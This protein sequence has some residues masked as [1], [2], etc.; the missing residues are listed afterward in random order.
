MI[1]AVPMIRHG[2][3]AV[4]LTALLQLPGAPVQAC[5]S[6]A[7]AV[8]MRY[9]DGRPRGGQW[10]LDLSIRHIDQSRRFYTNQAVDT[11]FRPRIDL[12]GRGYDSFAHQE[13]SAAMSFVQ[14]EVSRGITPSL[15]ASATLP[16][17]RHTVIDSLHFM[18]FTAEPQALPDHEHP[19]GTSTS[20][21]IPATNA[22]SGIGDLQIGLQNVFWSEGTRDLI[23]GVVVKV[24]TGAS[25]RAGGDGVIDPMLQPGT[26]AVD[27]V[28]SLQYVQ[29]L[30]PT[31]LSATASFQKAT[32]NSA[33]YRYGDDAVAAISAARPLSPRV[34]GQLQMKAQRSGRH[35]FEGSAVPS[36]GLFLVQVAPGVRVRVSPSLSAYATLQMPAYVHVNE[37]QLAPRATMTAGF[38]KTF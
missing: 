35:R 28:G 7:C 26:G 38:A 22:A 1:L 15:T 33:R 10:R 23:G 36:T 2:I 12:S 14:V 34:T 4:V 13:V 20:I 17:F 27:I 37:G 32:A 8:A 11:V 30:G 25:R 21:A 24:P 18:P 16:L 29:R 5:D 19:A 3:P 9:A 31:T 6:T